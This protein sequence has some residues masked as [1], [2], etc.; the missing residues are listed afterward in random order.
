MI[1]EKTILFLIIF[2]LP[3]K[4]FSATKKEIMILP[5]IPRPGINESLA[6]NIESKPMEDLKRADSF[7]IYDRQPAK[8]GSL[9]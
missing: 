2:L 8:E 5:V 1:C 6:R 7:I 4:I 9:N 3:V